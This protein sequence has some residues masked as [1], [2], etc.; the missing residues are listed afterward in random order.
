[1]KKKREVYTS[2]KK[3]PV[4]R[5]FDILETGKLHHLYVSG[6]G[7][8]NPLFEDIWLD[9][10]QQYFDEFGVDD[11]FKIRLQKMKKLTELGLDYII[12]GNRF[13]L[14]EIARIDTDLNKN[15][16]QL[17]TSNYAVKS[18]IE[19]HRKYHIDLEKTTV[20]EWGHLVRDYE[21]AGREAKAEQLKH[22]SKG[23][24]RN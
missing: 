8:A 13:L 7:P 9:L 2:I 18:A 24:G 22:K 4:T 10:Q 23:R 1:M 15:R 12:T 3:L 14:N 11:S 20:I 19:K 6:K 21:K 16:S 5:W 17:K